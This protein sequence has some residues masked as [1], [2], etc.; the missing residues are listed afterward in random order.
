[1]KRK[2]PDFQAAAPLWPL[3]LLL[4][5]CGAPC[6]AQAPITNGLI[7]RWTGDGNVKDSAGHFDGA[8]SGGLTYGTG[9]TGQAFQFNGGDARVDFGNTIGNFETR[10][11]TIAYWMKTDSRK[12]TEAFLG[13][14]TTCDGETSFW[15]IRIAPRESPP[16]TLGFYQ[17]GGGYRHEYFTN[18]C[19]VSSHPMNDGQWH[20]VAWV[21]QSTSSGTIT[22]LLYVDGALDNSKPFPEPIDLAN[23]S[24]LVMGQSVCQCCDG[25]RPYSGAAA[26]LQ[27]FSHALTA[28]EILAI[29]NAGK[30]PRVQDKLV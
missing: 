7:A 9:P 17:I 26:E 15:E 14:R 13:K 8:V 23:Q 2:T 21:R 27:I 4:T 24:P 28:E 29:C 1:M 16:G 12:Q 3:V 25:T 6:L 30:P 18:C 19:L 11:F 5:A 10:D 20:H 22:C